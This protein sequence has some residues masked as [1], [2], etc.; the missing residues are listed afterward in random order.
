MWPLQGQFH[1]DSS[2]PSGGVFF[3]HARGALN[4]STDYLRCTTC[5][6][7]DLFS[8]AYP[9]GVAPGSTASLKCTCCQGR[10]WH[11]RFPKE[12]YNPDEHHVMNPPPGSVHM[13]LE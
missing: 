9:H 10:P 2:P 5:N 13:V 11:D 4:M 8:L 7:L 12:P 3:Y 1:T 6:T